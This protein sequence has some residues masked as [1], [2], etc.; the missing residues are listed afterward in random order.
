MNLENLKDQCAIVVNSCDSYEDVWP[1][2][3]TALKD[4]WK[5]C[6]LEIYLN[7][8]SKLY[9]F[10]G[11]K[12]NTVNHY[13]SCNDKNWG[14][15]LIQSLKHINKK[16][17]ISL[18]DDFI[19]EKNINVN[20]IAKC[21]EQLEKHDDIAVF[22]FLNNPGKNKA[23]GLLEGFELLGRNND[24]KLNSAPA[25]WRRKSLINYT[26]V[27][28]SPWAWEAFGSAR[29]YTNKERFYA[30]M[31]GCEDIFT[32][33]HELGGA[34][35]RGKWVEGVVLPLMDKYKLDIDLSKRGIVEST[36]SGGYTLKWKINFFILGYEM[37][38]WKILYFLTSALKTKILKR[39]K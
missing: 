34:I 32:Y 5:D 3:F 35:R 8:E 13:V 27:I 16:Y 7:T 14:N 38:G 23:D 15:R 6:D 30:P 26:G 36:L 25:V 37:V 4:R 33:K 2:F 10:D 9:V 12:L 11:L 24:Y 1:L 28:D 22:Y 31:V 21:V 19:V 20:K 29:T 18:F 17:V 39:L